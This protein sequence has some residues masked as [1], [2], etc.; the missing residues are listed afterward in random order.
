MPSFEHRICPAMANAKRGATLA[1]RREIKL[2]NRL[3]AA[4]ALLDP[5]GNLSWA[6]DIML[7]AA[8]RITE[9]ERRVRLP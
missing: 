6:R 1:T 5:D 4:A 8:L 3:R 9:L 2:H 7:E